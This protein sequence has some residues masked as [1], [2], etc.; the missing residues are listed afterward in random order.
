MKKVKILTGSLL[1]LMLTLV[2]ACSSD[3]DGY[4]VVVNPQE[5]IGLWNVVK[6]DGKVHQTNVQ[7]ELTDYE[8][9]CYQ[10]GELVD[11][12]DYTL[13]S[14]AM[15]ILEGKEEVATLNF[16]SLTT[17]SASV[18]I[19]STQFGKHSVNLKRVR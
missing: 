14:D 1:L 6:V 7:L 4:M 12:Y 15:H 17:S 16:K 11:W 13:M 3:D 19:K 8:V 18:V 9:N 5:I 10:D 2:T